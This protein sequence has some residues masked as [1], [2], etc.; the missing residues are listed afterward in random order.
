MHGGL[1]GSEGVV[2]RAAKGSSL[3]RALWDY[4]S[5]VLLERSCS[6]GPVDLLLLH[7]ASRERGQFSQGTSRSNSKDCDSCSTGQIHWG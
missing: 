1:K 4:C 2:S 6:T 3:N 7:L 5:G